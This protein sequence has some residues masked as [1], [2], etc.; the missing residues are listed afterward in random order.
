[1]EGVGFVGVQLFQRVFLHPKLACQTFC[2]TD[3]EDCKEGNRCGQNIC[4]F[5]RRE[6]SGTLE[7][8]CCL[9]VN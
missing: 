3:V 1:M 8:K 7:V 2:Y 5:S 6:Q 9:Q 4:Q